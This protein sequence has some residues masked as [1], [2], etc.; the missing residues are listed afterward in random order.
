MLQLTKKLITLFILIFTAVN[1]YADP[2]PTPVSNNVTVG[3]YMVSVHDL[4]FGANTFG[5]DFW[6]WMDYEQDSNLQPHRTME[7]MNA[8][9]ATTSLYTAQQRGKQVW[10]QEK[11]Q[12]T[13]RHV[14]DMSNFPFDRHTL[15]IMTEE[16]A[17]STDSFKYLSDIKNSG[18]ADDVSIDGFVIKNMVVKNTARKYNTNFGDPQAADT[19][20]YSQFRVELEVERTSRILFFKLHTALYTAFL[21]SVLC[22]PLLAQIPKT[23]QMMGAILSAIVG[24]IFASIINLRTADAV[25]GRSESLTLVDRLHFITFLYFIIVGVLAIIVSI[26]RERWQIDNLYRFVTRVGIL[27]TTSYVINNLLL[28]WWAMYKG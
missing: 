21:I 28:I 20:T 7:L 8:K 25:I 1:T 22:F 10:A 17:Q 6:I 3:V 14:W 26:T 19:S 13:F 18:Y 15:V 16:S 12:G 27:Y 5:A 23:P 2:V 4:N 24:S 9:T 11:V